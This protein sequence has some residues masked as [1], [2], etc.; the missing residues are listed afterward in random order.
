MYRLDG[1]KSECAHMRTHK[2]SRPWQAVNLTVISALLAWRCKS[3]SIS[4]CSVDPIN[5]CHIKTSL[6]CCWVCPSASWNRVVTERDTQW[7]FPET[8]LM[9]FFQRIYLFSIFRVCMCM[10]T[11]P[12]CNIKLLH[13][14]SHYAIFNST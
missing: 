4:E 3:H 8:N 9:A 10:S 1:Y 7:G 13:K 6:C 2:S 14:L 11:A 5:T 12:T